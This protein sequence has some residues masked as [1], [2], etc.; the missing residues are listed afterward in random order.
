MMCDLVENGLR[1][2]GG[3][4]ILFEDHWCHSLVQRLEVVAVSL[5]ICPAFGLFFSEKFL[6]T[7]N[8]GATVWIL[9]SNQSSDPFGSMMW[10]SARCMGLTLPGAGLPLDMIWSGMS[11]ACSVVAVRPACWPSLVIRSLMRSCLRVWNPLEQQAAR[12]PYGPSICVHGLPPGGG[13]GHISVPCP[14]QVI[15]IFG[16][17][18]V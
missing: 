17:D 12:R 13:S 1:L 16:K 2:W 15:P 3:P 11:M 10:M 18:P 9:T 8:S 6:A 5:A 14:G 7:L 4:A